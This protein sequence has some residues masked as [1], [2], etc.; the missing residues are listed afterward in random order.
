M[1]TDFEEA[2]PHCLSET[3]VIVNLMTP[4]ISLSKM[5]H[6]SFLQHIKQ[7]KVILLVQTQ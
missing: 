4:L 3:V 5:L 1:M 2:G 6:C 7:N